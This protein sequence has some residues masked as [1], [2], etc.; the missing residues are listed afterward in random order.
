MELENLYG[1]MAAHIKGNLRIIIFMEKEYTF[2]LMEENTMEIGGIT[3][4][5]DMENLVGRMEGNFIL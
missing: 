2:G 4:W 3:K 1:Q 5:R